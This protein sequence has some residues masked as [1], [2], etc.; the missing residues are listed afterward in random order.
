MAGDDMCS[1]ASL[2]H[3]AARRSK[4]PANFTN[5]KCLEMGNKEKADAL[6]RELVSLT[7]GKHESAVEGDS[8]SFV[9]FQADMSSKDDVRTLVNNV[10]GKMGRLY[11]VVSNAGW[12]KMRN[13]MDLDD[14]MDEG[15]WDR[16][17]AVNVKS[18]L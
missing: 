13:F 18:H 6:I 4:H 1:E 5:L 12:T 15:D 11:V 8:A 3:T 16:C 10:Q 14:N 9:A 7:S 17:F 2:L